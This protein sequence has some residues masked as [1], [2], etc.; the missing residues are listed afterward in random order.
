M[1]R[2]SCSC[3]PRRKCQVDEFD[4]RECTHDE[5]NSVRQCPRCLLFTLLIRDPRA[6]EAG[7]IYAYD[8]LCGLTWR[9]VN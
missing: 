5:I 1:A 7:A 9:V 3:P 2:T 4:H 8:P 6:L